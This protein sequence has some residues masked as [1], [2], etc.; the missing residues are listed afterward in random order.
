MEQRILGKTGFKISALAFGGIVVRQTTGSDA[1]KFVADAVERGVNYFDV[2]PSYGDAQEMLGPALEPHRSKVYLACK[3]GARTKK[4][5]LEALQESFKLLHTDYF[6]V[7]QMHG[8]NPDEV[9]TVLGPGGA[10]EALVE[11]KKKGWVRNIGF[12]T[13]FDSV[14]LMLMAS[15]SFDTMLFPINWACWIKNGLGQKALD[16]ADR[17]NLGRIAIKALAHRAKDPKDDDYPKCWYR[18]IIDDNELAELAL[19][20]TLSRNV[21]TAVS[22]G[23][24]RMLHL[25]L[26][27][28]EKYSGSPPPLSP[29]EF[30]ELKKR[31]ALVEHT[32]FAE[33][34]LI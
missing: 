23:D 21:H 15:H 22:P 16:E 19:R 6:D 29:E 11:A 2:A 17:Q 33:T 3:T 14:A 12:T 32:I 27:I 20:F 25:A 8:V 13:H 24:I 7:Y 30:T 4:E 28:M 10:V 34:G 9:D 18:P 26:S 5:A 31:A 1:A